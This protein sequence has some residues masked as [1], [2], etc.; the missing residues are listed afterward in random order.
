MALS[1]AADKR[2]AD[3]VAKRDYLS[4]E[5]DYYVPSGTYNPTGSGVKAPSLPAITVVYT[6]SSFA[7]GASH[8]QNSS[9]ANRGKV[10]PYNQQ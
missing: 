1:K 5:K 7:I 10:K 6:P 2:Q 3:F 8:I 9:A 4:G